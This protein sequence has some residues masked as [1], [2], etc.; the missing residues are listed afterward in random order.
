[1]SENAKT[2]TFVVVGLLAVAL[3]LWTAPTSA[4]LDEDSLVGVN[5]TTAFD[6]PDKAKR[7]RIVRIDEDTAVRHE[8]EV[9]EE[10]G[11]WSIPSKDGYP[12][13]AAKQMAEAATSLMG[14]KVLHVASENAGDHEQYGVIDPLSDKI[15]PG[16]KGI[17]TRVTMWD[18]QNTPLA[19][20]II[21]KAVRDAEGQRYARKAGQD[22]VYVIEID[23]AKLSTNFEDWIEKDLLK[24]NAWELQQVQIKDYSAELVPVVTQDGQFSIQP[25]WDPR[26]EMTFNY[27][28]SDAKWS[29][30]KLREFDPKKGAHG[31]YV[32]FKPAPDEE[33]NEEALNGLKNA[34]GDLKIVDVE[35]KPKGLSN[36][37][38]AGKDFMNNRE[39]LK[40]LMSKGFTPAMT[41]EGGQQEILSSDGEAIATMKNGTEYV[42]RFGSLTNVAGG[43]RDKEEKAQNKDAKTGAADKKADKSDVHRYM[44]VMARFDKS[45][46]KQPE[47]QKLPDLPAKTE[48]KADQPA[49]SAKPAEGAAPKTEQKPAE[50]QPPANKPDAAKAKEGDAK[51]PA[52]NANKGDAAK[53][54]ETA[55]KKDNAAAKKSDAAANKDD[56]SAKKDDAAAKTAPGQDKQLEKIIADRKRIEQENQRKL[57]EYQALLKKG[58]ENVKELNQRFGDWYFVVNDDVF[59]KIRLSRDKVIKKKEKPKA[60]STTGKDGK[61]DS[62]PPSAGIPGLPAIPGASK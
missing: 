1:M 38:K 34:L 43:G 50:P 8:F 41:E 25:T 36:D 61:K 58:D 19:D 53:K 45:A 18:A 32:D 42:L 51:P 16:Q 46:V 60:A 48:A 35:R 54:D 44:F 28:D 13:D 10:N 30:A 59:R 31:E 3:G 21:G 14:R 2:I 39:A 12:A 55:A 26:A 17:G 47:L 40:D 56:A 11:L 37:L 29:A 49:A 9:A 62:A 15:E 20:L 6:S 5:L 33:L 4:K 7:L 52:D 24:L 23:P 57:D 27:N 22:V